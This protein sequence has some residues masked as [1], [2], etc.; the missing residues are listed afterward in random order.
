MSN[1]NNGFIKT[2]KEKGCDD[3]AAQAELEGYRSL[4]KDE[5]AELENDYQAGCDAA[6][7]AH[8]YWDF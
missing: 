2:I 3:A 1:F 4:I 8:S 6:L 5:L 7:E